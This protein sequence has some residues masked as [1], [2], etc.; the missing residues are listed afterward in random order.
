VAIG[1]PVPMLAME[2]ARDRLAPGA[3]LHATLGAQIYAPDE[4]VA[5]GY[6]DAAFAPDEVLPHAIQEAA[7]LG[8]LARGAYRATKERLRGRT[9]AYITAGLDADMASLLSPS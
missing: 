5:E 2:L 6:L 3:L 8:A 1:L 9:I 4:A 7:R